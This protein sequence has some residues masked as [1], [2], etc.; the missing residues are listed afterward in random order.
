MSAITLEKLELTPEEEKTFLSG[1][2]FL[3]GNDSE[4]GSENSG[5]QTNATEGG[6]E[7]DEWES[8]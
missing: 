2:K 1:S 6:S 8:K 7:Q 4:T 3:Y 5:E